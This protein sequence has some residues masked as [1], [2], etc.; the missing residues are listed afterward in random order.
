M[1][2]TNSLPYAKNLPR[3][4]PNSLESKNATAHFSRS[5]PPRNAKRKNAKA[6]RNRK[7]LHFT[8]G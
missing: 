7:S 6:K 5:S 2:K 8:Y 3:R 4:K 1:R